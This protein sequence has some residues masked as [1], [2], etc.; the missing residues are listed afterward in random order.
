M[1]KPSKRTAPQTGVYNPESIKDVA[2]SL[3]ISSLPDSIASALASDVEYRLHQVIEEAAR[4][5]RHGKR[6]TL[7]TADIDQALKVLNI[8]PLYGHTSHNP[9]TF[10]KALPFPNAAAA[11]TVYFVED[12]EIDFDRVLR[13]E[14]I[15]LPKSVSWTAHW[16]AVEGVQP[17]VPEN[18][19]VIPQEGDRPPPTDARVNGVEVTP[20]GGVTKVLDTQPHAQQQLVKQVLSR[21]LQLYY[22]RL[23]S[24][25]LP[26]SSDE[27]K[28]A[29]ALSSL[30]SD[31][32]LQALLPYI[33]RWVNESVVG[34]LKAGG[35]S[36]Q[37]GATLE[38]MLQVIAALMQNTTLFVEPYLHQLLPPLLSLLLHNSLPPTQS[39]VL[40]SSAAQTLA[41]LLQQYATTYPSL[42]PR[43]MKTLLLALVSQDKGANVGTRAGAIRGLVAVGKEAVRKGLV[44]SG[45][46][47][48]IGQDIAN[49]AS[50]AASLE[51]IVMDAL[52]ILRPGSDTLGDAMTEPLYED[53][54]L[55]ER[56][57]L[58]VGDHF[59]QKLGILGDRELATGILG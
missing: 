17:N 24:S 59:A 19:P 5:M 23:T 14:K 22:S 8:E 56:L 55:M 54:E 44:E 46:V 34:V 49:G 38:I 39:A 21:E 52:K 32:G 25:L 12:E 53:A 40:R 7:T 33:I 58:L 11:G 13:E 1:S 4:F 27:T 31:A 10:R 36:T 3:G 26:A 35:A 20:S 37:D 9:P 2:D 42:S 15:A 30:Q 45:G 41:R 29:A 47:R 18:P 16:L 28:R 43:I 51:D 57:K 6:T 48:I 50:G